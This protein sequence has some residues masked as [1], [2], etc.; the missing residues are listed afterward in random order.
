MEYLLTH[1][2]LAPKWVCARHADTR[3]FTQHASVSMENRHT[4]NGRVL[5]TIFLRETWS[6][7]PLKMQIAHYRPFLTVTSPSIR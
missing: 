7:K 6:A 3:T 5:R 4:A 1:S 2:S